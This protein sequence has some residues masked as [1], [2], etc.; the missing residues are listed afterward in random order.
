MQQSSLEVDCRS[1]LFRTDLCGAFASAI[2]LIHQGQEKREGHDIRNGAI[3]SRSEE[4]P[5][6]CFQIRGVPLLILD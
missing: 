4:S 3:L 2:Q 5:H 1:V 6:L